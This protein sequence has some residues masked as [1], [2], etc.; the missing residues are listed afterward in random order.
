MTHMIMLGKTSLVVCQ[1]IR[2]EVTLR[3]THNGQMWLNSHGEGST[4]RVGIL[5]NTHC[6]FGG[7]E[8]TIPPQNYP[9]VA[10]VT[11]PGKIY[12]TGK[13]QENF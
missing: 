3:V 7:S 9:C 10:L 2:G 4:P 8:V 13:L 11:Q 1:L 6:K 12:T 5:K